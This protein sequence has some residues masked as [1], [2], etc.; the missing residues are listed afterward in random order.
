MMYLVGGYTTF[1]PTATTDE[2]FAYDTKS[3]TWEVLPPLPAPRAGGCSVVF[4]GKLY[5]SSI[6]ILH[7]RSV[8]H[9]EVVSDGIV[10]AARVC[11]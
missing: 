11:V 4:E 2:A 10:P 6:I 7:C 5:I 1:F 9:L 8:N 3:D